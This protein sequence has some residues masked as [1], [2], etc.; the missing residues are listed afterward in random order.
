M[1]RADQDPEARAK[2]GI[3][4]LI[5]GWRLMLNDDREMLAGRTSRR[6][7]WSARKKLFR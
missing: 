2:T 3:S 6:S 5:A 1:R 4:K 7:W